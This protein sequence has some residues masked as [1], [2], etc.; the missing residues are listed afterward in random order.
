LSATSARKRGERPAVAEHPSHQ[1]GADEPEQAEDGEPVRDEIVLQVGDGDAE[2][3][4]SEHGDAQRGERRPVR[5]DGAQPAERDDKL[6]GG[7]RGGDRK[8]AAA[9][10]AP[11]QEPADDGD[12]LDRPDRP[13]ALRAAR[14]GGDDR[15]VERPSRHADVQ[16]GADARADEKRQHAIERIAHRVSS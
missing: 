10:A 3:H 13:G 7:I 5:G 8:V 14:R 12:V 1:R 6:D 16:E 11:E 2:E 4:G 15:E 9:T